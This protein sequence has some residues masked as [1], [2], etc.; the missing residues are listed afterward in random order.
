MDQSRAI[1]HFLY[2]LERH[3]ALSNA[4]APQVVIGHTADYQA[5]VSAIIEQSHQTTPLAL[6][7]LRLDLEPAERLARAIIDC[8][9]YIFSTT[10]RPWPSRAPTA[11]NFSARCTG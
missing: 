8:D 3:P 1:R 2:Y 6:S 5:M 10:P 4:R 11:R 9:L 7:A